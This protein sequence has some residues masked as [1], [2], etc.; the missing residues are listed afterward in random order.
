[1]SGGRAGTMPKAFALLF[2]KY[3][4]ETKG[5]PNQKPHTKSNQSKNEYFSKN[6]D[7]I[8][9]LLSTILINLRSGS[10]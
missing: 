4:I 3:L 10:F 9:G 5:V 6:E 7:E 8:N 1:M 2:G